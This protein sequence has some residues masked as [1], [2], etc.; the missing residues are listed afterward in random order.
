LD[1]AGSTENA[2]AVRDELVS[3]TRLMAQAPALERMATHPGIP[4]EAKERALTAVV[5]RAG[6]AP[7]TRRLLGALLRRYRLERLVEI[8]EGLSD[9]L[10]QR[11]GIAVAQ[12]VSAHPLSDDEQAGLRRSLE[13]KLDRRV[14][15]RLSVR[16]EL[17]A[18][19][20]VQVDSMRWDASLEGQLSR[21]TQAL[22]QQG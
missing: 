15:L 16:P 3:F 7:L 20:V 10:H 14:E 21:L 1:A 22:A 9:L 2:V 11:L 6:Y 17:L 18:G 13:G 19:F 8:V 4:M 5:E 12:V